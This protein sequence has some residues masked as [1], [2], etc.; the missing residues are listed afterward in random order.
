MS[1][2]SSA[3]PS[4]QDL[5]FLP[6]RSIVAVVVSIDGKTPMPDQFRVDQLANLVGPSLFTPLILNR[7]S[8]VRK[9]LLFYRH[10]VDDGISRRSQFS[11][12][13]WAKA[14]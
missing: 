12:I 8:M 11:N 2:S 6:I 10:W 14:F 4:F 5:R 7:F 3:L 9:L 13:V 1:L